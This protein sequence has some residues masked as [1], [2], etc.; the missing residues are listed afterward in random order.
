MGRFKR[1][2]ALACA[3]LVM[4]LTVLAASPELHALLHESHDEAGSAQGKMT[5][6]DHGGCASKLPGAGDH[7]GSLPLD[8]VGCVVTLYSQGLPVVL[9][10]PALPAIEHIIETVVARPR[11]AALVAAVRHLRPPTQAP[12]R[13]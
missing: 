7:S 6:C 2:T 10:V 1:F 9:D 5:G 3:G 13:A 12:P 8:D 11:D 4:V